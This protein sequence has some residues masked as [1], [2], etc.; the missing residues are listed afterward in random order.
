M[1]AASSGTL[2]T[3]A[4]DEK[5]AGG[6]LPGFFGVLHTWGRQLPYHPHIHY[7]VPDGALSTKDGKWHPTQEA[8]FAPVTAL[9]KVYKAKFIAEIKKAGLYAMRSIQRFGK[10]PLSFIFG[11]LIPAGSVLNIWHHT[12]LRSPSQTI[13]SLRWKM[14][15][16]F[17]A[18][19]KPKATVG[20]P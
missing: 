12:S 20:A 11:R 17:S 13:A 3:F 5:W 4:H 7:V 2:K 9:S 16:S 19:K 6:D 10:N 8:Y 15:A 1:F 14:I 18:I